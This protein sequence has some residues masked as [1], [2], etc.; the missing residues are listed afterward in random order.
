MDSIL[1]P[2]FASPTSKQCPDAN[3]T[4]LIYRNATAFEYPFKTPTAQEETRRTGVEVLGL[5]ED[6]LIKYADTIKSVVNAKKAGATI[7]ITF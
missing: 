4:D 3:G 6:D 7:Q 5:S 2:E 1:L